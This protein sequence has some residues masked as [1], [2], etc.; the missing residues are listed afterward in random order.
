MTGHGCTRIDL[1]LVNMVARAAFKK[2]EQVYGQGIAKHSMLVADYDLPAFG[3]KVSMPRTPNSV[4]NLE[5]YELPEAVRE[6]LVYFAIPPATMTTFEECL[7][8]GNF[9]DAMHI[10]F[11]TKPRRIISRFRLKPAHY[12]RSAGAE[13]KFPL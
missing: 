5:R 1:V 2:Y 12:P 3:A 9:T 4:I 10:P 6:E 8:Q 13:G 7:S 11:G